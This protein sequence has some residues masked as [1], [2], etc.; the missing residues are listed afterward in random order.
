MTKIFA[1]HLNL[2]YKFEINCTK[3]HIIRGLISKYLQSFESENSTK[4][5]VFIQYSPFS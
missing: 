1:V 5:A 4:N 3:S 2:R